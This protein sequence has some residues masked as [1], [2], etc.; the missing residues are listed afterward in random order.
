VTLICK[1]PIRNGIEKWKNVTYRI[2]WFAEGTLLQTETKCDG[3]PVGGTNTNA[4]PAGRVLTSKLAGNLYKI[5]QWVSKMN[6]SSK[7]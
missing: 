5:G 7:V 2:E 3:F 4:C 6:Q 1:V